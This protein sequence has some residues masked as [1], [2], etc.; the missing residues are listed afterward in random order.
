MGNAR[1]EATIRDDRGV[2]HPFISSTSEAPDA[3]VPTSSRIGLLVVGGILGSL[4]LF[5]AWLDDGWVH[6]RDAALLVVAWLT[7]GCPNRFLRGALVALAAGMLV[8][9]VA[10]P[11][12]SGFDPG[13]NVLF[14]V[15]LVVAML[16]DQS[17]SR[18]LQVPVVRQR[19]SEKRRAAMLK[20]GRCPVCGTR[21]P[22]PSSAADAMVTCD[23]CSAAWR[24][25]PRTRLFDPESCPGCSYSLLG[26]KF[27]DDCTVRCPE[28]G[29]VV[30]MPA[31]RVRSGGVWHSKLRCWGCGD[32]LVGL[33]LQ[34]G[35]RVQCPNC[36]QWR[37]G[38][39]EADLRAPPAVEA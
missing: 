30:L 9:L 38:L 2:E 12:G 34:Y 10:Q 28:C 6:W 36:G 11:S 21:L 19:E 18:A 4:A 22:T 33:Q 20:R 37:S 35:D 26:L 25:D 8:W 16:P 39:R 24:V 32:S 14:G 31:T 3:A 5:G 17:I 27:D 29:R 7:L 23:Q 15:W 1:T 13:D